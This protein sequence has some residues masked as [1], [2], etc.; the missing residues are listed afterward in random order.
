MAPI[1]I[2]I[3]PN[4]H[5]LH[6]PMYLLNKLG[7]LEHYLSARYD[8]LPYHSLIN[9][10]RTFSPINHLKWRHT[11][12]GVEDVVVKELFQLKI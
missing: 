12:I 9:W 5:N 10:S 3:L 11:N 8:S 2:D 7:N 1:Y 6:A 4:L